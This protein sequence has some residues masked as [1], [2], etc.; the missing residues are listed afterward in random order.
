MNCERADGSSVFDEHRGEIGGDPCRLQRLAF[1]R[2]ARIGRRVVDDHDAA[3][4]RLLG[5][6]AANIGPRKAP[7]HRRHAVH[8]VDGDRAFVAIDLAI[9]DAAHAEMPS[10]QPARFRQNPLGIAQRPDGIAQFEQKRLSFLAPAQRVFRGRAFGGCPCALARGLDQRDLV[11]CPDAWDR[12]VDG[13][14]RQP[15]SFLVQHHGHERRDLVVEERRAFGVR[16]SGVATNVV[17]GDR[18]TAP[19]CVEQCL[20]KNC[21]RPPADK[22]RYTLGIGPGDD[23]L[24]AVDLRVEHAVDTK[25]LTEQARG[26]LLDLDRTPQRAE[27]VV[28]RDEEP[29]LGGRAQRR[30]FGSF[31]GIGRDGGIARHGCGTRILDYKLD[32]IQDGKSARASDEKGPA[33][34]A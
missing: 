18:V 34:D 14:G 21:D 30:R 11:A 26:H 33:F 31:S 19:V 23:E 12:A 3:P 22:R 32:E 2:R 28:E 5:N 10:Q 1:R 9:R 27:P 16:E 25:V 17:D 6:A 4:Q 13:E 15:Q 24:I 20:A 8:V 29:P 7:G